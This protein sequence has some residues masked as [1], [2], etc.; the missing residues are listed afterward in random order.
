MNRR[1][2]SSGLLVSSG[3]LATTGLSACQGDSAH[4]LIGMQLPL[5]KGLFTDGSVFDMSLTPKPAIIKF[6]GM[7]CGP[8]MLDMPNWLSVVR[9]LRTGE[10]A[11]PDISIL[12][13]HVGLA[14]SNG[15]TL[16]QWVAAQQTDVA[17]SVVDDATNAIMKATHITGTPSTLYVDRNGRIEEHVWQF[18]NERGVNSFIRKVATLHAKDKG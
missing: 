2:F 7:W 12:T 9:Q 16:R 10:H 13:V 18:K 8:C 6:W 3:V 1:D 11:L 17:T 5:V 15:P 14:P 4:L